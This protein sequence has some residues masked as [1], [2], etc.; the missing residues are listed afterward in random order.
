[1]T[2]ERK[3]ELITNIKNNHPDL[4]EFLNSQFK[5]GNGDKVDEFLECHG[6]EYCNKKG[7]RTMEKTTIRN[8]KKGEFFTLKPIE[9]P[10]ESQVW[11]KDSYDKWEKKWTCIRF[12]DICTSKDLS[13]D[14]IVYTGFTF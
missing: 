1:M 3:G 8:L 9:D 14:K 7:E 11:V 6:E 10:K 2:N 13:P 5:M 12:D 4:Y